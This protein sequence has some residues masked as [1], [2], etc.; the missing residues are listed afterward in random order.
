M[1]VQICSQNCFNAGFETGSMIGYDTYTGS[2]DDQGQ[3]SINIP[4]NDQTQLRVMHVTEGFDPVAKANCIMN[5]KLPV[6]P[7]G[8]GQ[9]ALRLGDEQAGFRAARILL[10]F[11]V[12][13]SGYT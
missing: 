2:I 6:V 11:H 5:T 7:K 13:P 10:N 9:Y 4:S 12:T 3:V 1:M 8:R